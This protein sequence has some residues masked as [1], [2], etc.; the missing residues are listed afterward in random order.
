MTAT[1][2]TQSAIDWSVPKPVSDAE[3]AFPTRVIGY[4][5]PGWDELPETFQ[6]GT[7]GYENLAILACFNGI[8]LLSEALRDEVDAALARRQLI[9]IVRSF[10]PKH[11]HKEAAIA[12]LL[13][14][15]IK[16]HEQG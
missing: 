9:A 3:F 2:T 13:S 11:E 14:L 5:I 10:Q 8:E 4:F 6:Q 12:Y 1:S 15:W 7:S 16:P